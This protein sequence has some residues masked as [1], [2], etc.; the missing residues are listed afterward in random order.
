MIRRDYILR[1][2]EEFL[3]ALSRI[4]SLKK[5]QHFEQS[6]VALDEEFNRLIGA[7]AEATARLS[8]TER[9]AKVMRGEPTQ[10]VQTKIMMLTTLLK[11][12][13]DLSSMRGDIESSR[14][15]YLKG[16][17][18]LLYGLAGADGEEIPAFVPKTEIFVAALSDSPLPLETAALLMQHL[19]RTRQFDKAEDTLFEMLE[20]EPNDPRM[21]EFGISFY[22]RLRT[23]PDDSLSAGNLPRSEV[24]AGL[25][26]LRDRKSALV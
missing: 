7:G 25:A 24:E 13:G 2:I 11:Q 6:A 10:V 9:L 21:L 23:Q 17:N 16:L 20:A 5:E 3:Q 19:E 4:R 22:E 26:E 18:L 8:E 15:C 1:M 12:A 14:I